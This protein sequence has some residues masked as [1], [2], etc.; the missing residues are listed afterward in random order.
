MRV[1]RRV[2]LL[3][4]NTLWIIAICYFY[5][6]L[7]GRQTNDIDEDTAPKAIAL[8]RHVNRPGNMTSLA[9]DAALAS[10]VVSEIHVWGDDPRYHGAIHHNMT[11]T[12]Y[13]KAHDT[14]ASDFPG[15]FL[16]QGSKFAGKDD[17]A[18]VRW[19]SRLALDM[20]AVLRAGRHMF[21]TSPLLYLENDA[22]LRDGNCL[23]SLLTDMIAQSIPAASCYSPSHR[24]GFYG[25]SRSVCFVFMPEIDPTPHLLAYHMVQPADWILSDFS[26]GKWPMRPCANHGVDGKHISTRLG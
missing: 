11:M 3:G 10:G 21:P 22:I 2:W 14:H 12:L 9:I 25:G 18:R 8:M 24:P 7:H 1:S 13:H 20:W 23:Q 16:A 5:V 4:A 17:S 19:R 15:E 6:F 26:M